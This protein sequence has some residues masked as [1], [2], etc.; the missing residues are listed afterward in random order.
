MLTND[1]ISGRQKTQRP[2]G[3]RY[4]LCIATEVSPK[5]G[6]A[7]SSFVS[8]HISFNTNQHRKSFAAVIIK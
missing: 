3:R 7:K 2:I 6:E 5:L 8:S 1:L 4:V